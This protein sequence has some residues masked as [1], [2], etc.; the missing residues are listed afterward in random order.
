MGI[1]SIER[2]EIMYCITKEDVQYE[3]LE[4]MGRALTEDELIATKKQLEFGIGESISF[5]YN[6]IFAEMD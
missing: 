2:G 5:I 1:N 4:K 3:A 6:A